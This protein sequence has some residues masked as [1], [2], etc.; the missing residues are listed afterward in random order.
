[1]TE[2]DLS[3][4]KAPGLS[5]DDRLALIKHA[6]PHGPHAGLDWKVAFDRDVDLAGRILRDVLKADQ[7]VPGR[8]GPRPALDVSRAEPTVD[9]WMGKDPT[10]RPYSMLP[11]CAA[12]KLLIGDHSLRQ[13]E[14][15]AKMSRNQLARLLHGDIQP[16]GEQMEAIAAA[17][18]K[19]ASW[20]VEYRIGSVAAAIVHKL[21]T[22]PEGSV[23][24][25]ESLFW[26]KEPA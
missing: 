17:F 20:F 14:R 10:A 8:P 13:V 3:A 19:K 26:Q 12:F 22:N 6:F 24:A 16:T 18:G 25:Y 7:A 4:F 2:R 21:T 5:W 11:F 1:M 23:K 9:E 15:R